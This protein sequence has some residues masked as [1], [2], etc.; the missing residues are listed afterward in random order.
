[1][2]SRYCLQSASSTTSE[3][4]SGTRCDVSQK[5]ENLNCYD[6]VG[7]TI[8]V[9]FWVKFSAATV[10]SIANSGGSS[11]GYFNSYLQY[12]T[13]T[14]DSASSTDT[15]DSNFQMLNILNGSLPTT[16]TKYSFTLTVPSNVNNITFRAQFSNLGSTTVASTVWFQ[17]AEIQLELGSIATA[18][19]R[20]PYGLE[21]ALCQRYYWKTFNI[22]T[23]PASLQGTAGALFGASSVTNISFSVTAY[24]PVPMRTTPTM[25]YYSPNQSGSN[26]SEQSGYV[27][28]L[29][30]LDAN[31]KAVALRAT[32]SVA[33]GG[34]HSIHIV[35]S[36]EL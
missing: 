1:L 9:S 23:L 11:F 35:A 29:V 5:I 33:A 2:Y 36:A 22:G 34:A 30:Q 12:N 18:F 10:T 17:I 28:T 21:L 14:T 7:R 3:A 19:E 16:W 26:W 31:E 20:R 25:T 8:T 27:P 6:L 15:G 13:T 4:A 24:F 32:T